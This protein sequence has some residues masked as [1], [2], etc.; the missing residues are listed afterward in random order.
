MRLWP[1]R[2]C[3]R[4]RWRTGAGCWAQPRRATPPFA[5]QLP[6]LRREYAAAAGKL[7]RSYGSARAAKLKLVGG[8][9]E[10]VPAA[11][12]G[13]EARALEDPSSLAGGASVA[14]AFVERFE[15]LLPPMTPAELAAA[16]RE[17]ATAAEEARTLDKEETEAASAAAAAAD[18][19]KTLPPMKQV[20]KEA[21]KKAEQMRKRATRMRLSAVA[22]AKAERGVHRKLREREGARAYSDGVE[23]TGAL[24]PT[25]KGNLRQSRTSHEHHL[26]IQSYGQW[27][28]KP[29]PTADCCRLFFFLF[30]CPLSLF[31]F[32]SHT[33]SP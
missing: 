8:G 27:S 13:G 19:S 32:I 3:P 10:A 29:T 24:S 20:T 25:K 11:V 33:L 14:L 18:V 2:A 9:A 23:L 30:F 16:A 5:Q 6:A 28:N 15:G 4:G 22:L 7:L 1:P 17:N 12:Q 21:T 31:L 26:R